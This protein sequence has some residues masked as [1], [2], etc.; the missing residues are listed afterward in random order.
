MKTLDQPRS[1]AIATIVADTLRSGS[2]VKFRAVGT[3]M[4]PAI[5]PGDVLAIKPSNGALPEVGTLP[6][7]LSDGLL[8]VHRV[9][10][11][12]TMTQSIKTRGDALSSLDPVVLAG[13]VLGTVV[14]RNGRSL[15]Q[16]SG[17]RE[18]LN[19]L[20]GKPP[21][22]WLRLKYRMLRLRRRKL[23]LARQPFSPPEPA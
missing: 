15:H 17:A 16:P 6:L 13:E 9:I 19:R 4:I 2:E 8:R 11:Q 1:T 21:L 3:S 5:W 12:S 14:S 7:T 22:R 18:H 10:E 23:K 20:S